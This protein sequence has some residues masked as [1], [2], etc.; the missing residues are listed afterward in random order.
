MLKRRK[1]LDGNNPGASGTAEIS[2]DQVSSYP[3]VNAVVFGYRQMAGALTGRMHL[4]DV[5]GSDVAKYSITSESRWS[6][7]VEEAKK[8]PLHDLYRRFAI[9]V[10]DSLAGVS[11]EPSVSASPE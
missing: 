9:D 8:D 6:V 10:A 1:L 3:T 2:I 4:I 5:N 11:R 7:A